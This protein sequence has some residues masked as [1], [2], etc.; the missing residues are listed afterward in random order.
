ME[1][2]LLLDYATIAKHAIGK[3]QTRIN[4]GVEAHVNFVEM[5]LQFVIHTLIRGVGVIIIFTI[6]M[7]WMN[8]L[9][10]VA[11][12][13]AYYIHVYRDKKVQ[14]LHKQVTSL[15]EHVGDATT[16]IISDHHLIVLNNA[17]HQE[18]KAI[19]KTYQSLP[20]TARLIDMMSNV[21][22]TVMDFLFRL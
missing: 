21:S 5:S 14:P 13:S 3:L 11:T 6:M 19:D 15:H 9:L 16:K 10:I 8:I 2:F 22:Y 7:P 18:L 12:I 1:Q 20:H 17:Q 4:Q